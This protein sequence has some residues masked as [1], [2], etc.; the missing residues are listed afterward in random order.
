MNIQNSLKGVGLMILMVLLNS[1]VFGQYYYYHDE[2]VPLYIDSS[3]VSI[4][5]ANGVSQENQGVIL[6]EFSRIEGVIV[7]SSAIDHFVTCSL[8]TGANYYAFIDSLEN[9]DGIA[10]AE[11]YYLTDY[12]IPMPV[13]DN[14]FVAFDP[15]L[16]ESQIDSIDA[17]YKVVR[18]RKL[19]GTE[20]I[21]VLQNTD[22]S[23]H[24]MLDLANTFHE[25]DD[26]VFAHPDFGIRCQLHSYKLY[27][28]YN[29]SQDHVK[30]VIGTF[31]EKSVWD[32]AGLNREVDV[33]VIDDGVKPHEDLPGNRLLQEANFTIDDGFPYEDIAHGQACAGL[34]AASHTTDS[35]YAG[36]VAPWT[37][38]I[39]MN[40]NAHIM[41]IRVFLDHAEIA[42]IA[43]GL[44]Y[45]Y[46]NNAEV[47][48]NSYGWDYNPGIMVID[49]LIRLNYLYGRNGLGTPMIFSSGNNAYW[50]PGIVG[51]PACMEYS[52]AVGA[53]DLDDER[54]WYSQY[55]VQLD[56]VAPS[57]EVC[58]QGNVWSLDYMWEEGANPYLDSI[59][60][61]PVAW[62]CPNFQNNDQD[63]NCHFGGTSAAAPIVA[64]IA[65]LLIARDSML[66]ANQIYDIIR[67]S[68]VTNLEWGQITVPDVEYG[69]GRADAYRA[70]LAIT[71]G[72]AN[73]DGFVNV[74]DVT[75]IISY[76]FRSGPEPT[77]DLRIADSNC[78][79]SIDL[80]DGV[81]LLNY[82]FKGGP[83]PPLCY[84]YDY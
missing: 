59:C 73:N 74:G 68:A 45:A 1:L 50:Y 51:Y 15:Q 17:Q 82:A 16:S 76:I 12:S 65:S 47:V 80:A 27:D 61:V 49:T 75:Y 60:G 37:G 66:T 56:V 14:F 6:S 48:S 63:Y 64:G 72:D 10:L 19:Y 52:L 44:S 42:W 23:G 24:H 79:G 41:P 53:V 9:K 28:Y 13:G 34:I 21:Y 2:Q 31:N 81:Y 5:F 33:A 11:P 20:S 3:K 22:S 84:E 39:S 18:V 8:S 46:T 55:G 71:R 83:P 57:G 29:G 62:N 38:M 40:P 30:K 54:W 67:H 4:L 25:R 69:Y 77:P 26:V 78:D 35:A 7:D 43:E 58:Y 36:V 70:M 32:F